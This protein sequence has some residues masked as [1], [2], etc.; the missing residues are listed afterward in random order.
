M[1]DNVKHPSHYAEGGP[2][3][4][5]GETIECIEVTQ[6]MNFNRG[7]AIKNLWRAGK[8]GGRAKEIEDLKKARQYIDFEIDRLKLAE[9]REEERAAAKGDYSIS[10][11]FVPNADLR[12]LLFAAERYGQE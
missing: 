12:G 2:L 9:A 3:H 10:M 5:C 4:K 1:T 6:T 11:T 7:N 8:K